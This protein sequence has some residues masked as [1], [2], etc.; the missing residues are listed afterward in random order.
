MF[1]ED[2]EVITTTAEV[3]DGDTNIPVTSVEN[4]PNT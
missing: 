1:I 3:N 2:Y 4:I